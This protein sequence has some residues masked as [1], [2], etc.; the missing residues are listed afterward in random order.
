[1]SR[2]ARGDPESEGGLV[3]ELPVLGVPTRFE[4]NSV[5]V[6]AA[7]EASFGGWRAV[8][9]DVEELGGPPLRVRVVV[10]DNPAGGGVVGNAVPGAAGSGA[11]GAPPNTDDRLA[12]AL[13]HHPPI[14]PAA[15]ST[16]PAASGR[17]RFHTPVRH[18]TPDS[19][20]LIV[21]A[22]GSIGI[23]DSDRRTALAYV[24]PALVA[25]DAHFRD[26]VLE[27]MTLNL[28]TGLDRH[29]MH[30][31][32]VARDGR[33]LLLAGGSGAGK[34]TLAFAAHGAGFDVLSEDRVWIQLAPRL[35]VWGWPGEVRLVSSS[36]APFAGS[37]G[38]AA[39]STRDGKTKLSVAIE[40]RGMACRAAADARVCVLDPRR[41]SE[42]S[43]VALS[44]GE[45]ATALTRDVA[46]GF[47]RFP[48]RHARVVATLAERG[49]WRLTLADDPRRAIPYLEAMLAGW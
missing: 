37:L 10:G 48:K 20:R 24:S 45:V 13:D 12:S 46:P 3:V 27:A 42:P 44:E 23:A 49:G 30:A 41:A 43:V 39:P 28:L 7:V 26:T 47:D 11:R 19:A 40:A 18:R 6:V 35:R 25:D 9:A 5:A 15:E 32:A 31:A 16:P 22:L 2:F 1:M 4:T 29:P 34:S 36:T 14:A 8:G 38:G 33:A 17:A 21:S